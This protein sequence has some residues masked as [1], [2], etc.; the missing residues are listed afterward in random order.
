MLDDFMQKEKLHQ[1]IPEAKKI[2]KM[3]NEADEFKFYILFMKHR[4]FFNEKK[5]DILSRCHPV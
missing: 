4:D 5:L 2:L 3:F 1:K